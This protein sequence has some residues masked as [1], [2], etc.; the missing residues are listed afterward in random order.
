[1]P[2]RGDRRILWR[3]AGVREARGVPTEENPMTE[4]ATATVPPAVN[5]LAFYWGS[6]DDATKSI[7]NQIYREAPELVLRVLTQGQLQP[8]PAH[9]SLDEV[10][11]R[12]D[13]DVGFNQ[14]RV[15]VAE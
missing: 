14:A 15:H 9:T 13:P 5:Q 6:L 12:A 10:V 7:F 8:D 4:S 3:G 11:A 2:Q 1:M